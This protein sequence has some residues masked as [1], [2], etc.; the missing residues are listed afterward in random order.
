MTP[1]LTLAVEQRVQPPSS[2]A[3]AAAL[4][5]RLRGHRR[6]RES[7]GAR[8]VSPRKGRLQAAHWS[9]VSGLCREKEGG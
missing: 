5:G 3:P 6:G 4:P 2:P 8:L 7:G 9:V 1:G